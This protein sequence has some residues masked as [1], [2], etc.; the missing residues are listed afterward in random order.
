MAAGASANRGGCRTKSF[1][2]GGC[3]LAEVRARE[4]EHDE[5][6]PVGQR[7]TEAMAVFGAHR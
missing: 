6:A 1:R 7:A 4:A 5:I 3:T 2:K